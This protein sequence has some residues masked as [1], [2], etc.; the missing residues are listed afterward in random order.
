VRRPARAA[1]DAGCLFA[2]DTDAHAVSQWRYA[3]IA[4]AHA[5]LAG[6]PPDRI[7]NT[8]P[9]ERLREWTARLS[10]A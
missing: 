5:R 2:V 6:I 8:W 10:A 4:L 7:V 9:L 3:E 1:L